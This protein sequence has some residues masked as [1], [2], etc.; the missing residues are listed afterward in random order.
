[1][2]SRWKRQCTR[3]L[4]IIIIIIISFLFLSVRGSISGASVA[5]QQRDEH[6]ET[7]DSLA[8]TASKLAMFV[9]KLPTMRIVRGYVRAA[10][11]AAAFS[12]A[13]LTI[14]MYLKTW[15]SS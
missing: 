1:M 8:E 5:E 13:H 12:P 7:A 11:D 14:G 3:Q 10:P 4:L 2:A 6:N 15:V 9:D